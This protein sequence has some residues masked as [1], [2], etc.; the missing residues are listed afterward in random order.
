MKAKTR[1][2]FIFVFALAAVSLQAQG[3]P[4]FTDSPILLGLEGSGLRTFGKLS[5]TEVGKTYT[6][7]FALPYNVT[8][9]F[10]VGAVQPYLFNFPKSGNDQSG[11][12]NLS[13]FGKYSVIQIDAKAKTFRGLLKFTQTFSTGSSNFSN[14]SI[15]TSQFAFVSGFVTTQYGLYASVGYSFIS[16]DMP[17]N[18]NYDFAFGYPLLPQKYPPFQLN[19]YLEFNGSYFFDTNAHILFITP[20][21]QFIGSSN[22]LIEAGLQ[23]PLINVGTDELKYNL[24]AGARFLFY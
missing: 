12:G 24:L 13:V 6:Q 15:T 9:D 17:D 5:S 14:N 19:S 22:F 21:I 8:A 23:L 1:I 11:W 18:L 10:Q 3:P 7:I 20:G 16:D 4:I 2:E